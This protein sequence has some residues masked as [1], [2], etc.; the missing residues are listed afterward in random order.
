M[1]DY[2]VVVDILTR[3]RDKLLSITNSM[4]EY[5]MMDYIRLEQVD[6]INKCL[7]ILEVFDVSVR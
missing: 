1:E 4:P 2:N 6:Q 7:E 3:H 5:G